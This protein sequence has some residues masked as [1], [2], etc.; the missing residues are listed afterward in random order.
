MAYRMA[1]GQALGAKPAEADGWVHDI[2]QHPAGIVMMPES[3]PA[4]QATGN[5]RIVNGVVQTGLSVVRYADGTTINA[6]PLR[7]KGT[8]TNALVSGGAAVL[9]VDAESKTFVNG[10]GGAAGTGKLQKDVKIKGQPEYA[11]LTP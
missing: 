3:P 1:E 8:V 10:L 9:A 5:V 2:L 11:E 6:K 7:M 4:D